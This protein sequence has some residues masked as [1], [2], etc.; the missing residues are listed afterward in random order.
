V[1]AFR[2][3]RVCFGPLSDW[4]VCTTS[5]DPIPTRVP[6]GRAPARSAYFLQLQ[7]DGPPT[8]EQKGDSRFSGAEDERQEFHERFLRC[9]GLLCLIASRVLDGDKGVD[10]AVENCFLAAI[11]NPQEFESEGSFRSWLLR[12]LINEALQILRQKS[13]SSTASHQSVFSE[14]R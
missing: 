11:C 7:L 6:A 9:R 1:S 3:T 4:P 14:Q 5:R 13:G 10:E 8:I 2:T 12:I